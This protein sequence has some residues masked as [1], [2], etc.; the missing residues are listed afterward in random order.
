ME[1]ISDLESEIF[2]QI[3]NTKSAT[4]ALDIYIYIYIHAHIYV[5][6]YIYIW[7]IEYVVISTAGF[8]WS[9]KRLS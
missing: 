3:K 9:L 8:L 6:I 2:H 4:D 7:Q 5:Y 1:L